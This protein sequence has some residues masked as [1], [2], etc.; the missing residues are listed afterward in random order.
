M[1][2]YKL[3]AK[4]VFFFTE[5]KNAELSAKIRRQKLKNQNVHPPKNG[6]NV[7]QVTPLEKRMIA[8]VKT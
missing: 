5:K 4:Y 7:I 3:N 8:D 2:D 1:K 6:V